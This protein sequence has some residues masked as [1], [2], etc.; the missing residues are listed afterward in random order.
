MYH[1]FLIHSFADGHLGCFQ[2]LVIVNCAT[3]NIGVHRFFW[4]GV[5]GF[6]GYNPS[7]GIAGSKGSSIFSFLRKLHTVFHS[8]CTSLHSHQQ[9]TRVLFST[10]P[11]HHLLFANLVIMAI[12][13]GVKWYIIVV[14]ICI[15]L[16]ARDTERPFIRLWTLSMSSLKKCLFKSFA[17][18]LIGL[19]VFLVWNH[20]SSLHILELKPLS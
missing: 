15:S 20:V 10:Q 13:T 3:M 6:L 8:G 4:I 9:C 16:M 5:S 7:S 19:F 11:H 18:F 12:L 2:N 17:H 14:L 1:N